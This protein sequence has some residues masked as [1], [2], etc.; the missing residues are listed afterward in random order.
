MGNYSEIKEAIET[1]PCVICS[2]LITRRTLDYDVLWKQRKYCS[3]KCVT[4]AYRLKH[5]DKVKKANARKTFR[6][7]VKARTD[8]EL[9]RAFQQGFL[10]LQR[11]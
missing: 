11:K 1:K 10:H 7:G 4:R 2:E 8:E 5:P 6:K 9:W 3:G